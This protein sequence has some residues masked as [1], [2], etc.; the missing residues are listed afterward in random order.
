MIAN[1]FPEPEHIEETI[2]TLKFATRMMKVSNEP[3]INVQQ[4]PQLLLKKY[5]KEI[6]DLK[7][8]LAMHDTLANKGKVNYDPYSAEQQY[9][10][11]KLAT[12]FMDGELEDI[13][14]LNSMR[15]VKE[16]FAQMRNVFR[17]MEHEAKTIEQR[18]ETLIG[19]RQ[20]TQLHELEKRK[21]LMHQD[22]V[23]DLEEVGEFGLGIAPRH[24]KPVHR[25]ELSKKKEEEIARMQADDDDHHG[26]E[27]EADEE[28]D[29]RLEV[30]KLM[31]QREAKRKPIDRQQAFL[32]FKQMAEGRT[33]ED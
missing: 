10:L 29:S 6:R 21:T 17:R 2:S 31:K 3:V 11:Q 8:E 13:E 7:Q 15:Q 16:L 9:E 22:G 4:D 30:L 23:G 27:E 24:I 19:Q 32:E 1:I 12:K 28:A 26:E 33:F 20:P 25:I 14:E 18:A 5:E